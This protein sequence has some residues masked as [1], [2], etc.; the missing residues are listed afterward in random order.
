[1]LRVVAPNGREAIDD[2]TTTWN[3]VAGNAE[4]AIAIQQP[5]DT[6]H[7]ATEAVV[8]AFEPSYVRRPE[9]TAT[10]GLEQ[11]A[12]SMDEAKHPSSYVSPH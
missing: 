12:K 3:D 7:L 8:G 9:R 6:R 4:D 2:H 10:G 5:F 11:I 1:M